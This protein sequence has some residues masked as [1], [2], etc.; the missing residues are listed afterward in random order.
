MIDDLA[1]EFEQV[2]KHSEKQASALGSRSVK[3]VVLQ[4][5]EHGGNCGPQPHRTE[6]FGVTAMRSPT[7]HMLDETTSQHS[8]GVGASPSQ[9]THQRWHRSQHRLMGPKKGLA[10]HF[11]HEN[12]NMVLSMMIGICMSVGR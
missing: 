3:D 9:Q 7:P 10:V 1:C 12:W 8:G 5:G 2:I 11:G 6:V 4:I